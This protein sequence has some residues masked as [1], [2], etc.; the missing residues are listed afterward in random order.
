MS[1]RRA[2]TIE[3]AF[4]ELLLIVGAIVLLA[5]GV[6]LLLKFLGIKHQPVI[7]CNL[8]KS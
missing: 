5:F 8:T 7:L 3:I 1:L 2:L 4:N 6:P